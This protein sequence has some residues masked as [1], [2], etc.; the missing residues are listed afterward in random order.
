MFE[1]K[2]PDLG[3]GVA[4]GQ[5]VS[6]L[7]KEGDAVDEFQPMFEVETDKAA[8]E[9][10]A[11]KSGTV[12]EVL[13]EK[14]QTVQVGEVLIKIDDAGDGGDGEDEKKTD[15]E[16]KSEAPPKEEQQ[17]DKQPEQKAGAQKKQPEKEKDAAPQTEA[18]P[19][20]AEQESADGV[21]PAAPAVRKLAREK[22]VD[23]RKV[24]PTGPRGR[25]LRED[26]E[27]AALSSDGGAL[28]SGGGAPMEVRVGELPD[29]TQWGPVRREPAP[30]IRKTIAKQM[31]TSWL[32][33]TRV[34]QT[35]SADITILEEARQQHNKRAGKSGTKMT[36]TVIILKMIAANL[37][38]HPKLNCSYDPSSGEIIWKDYVHIGVAVDTPRGLVVPVIRDVDQKPLATIADELNDIVGRAREAKFDVSELR[39]GTF[40]L[41]N[42]GPLGG[43]FFTPMVN[44]PEVGIL[45]LG[46]A[47]EQAVVRNGEIVPRLILPLSISYDHR[48]IDGA[49]GARF[50]GDLKSALESPLGVVSLL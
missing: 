49:D 50:C 22:G 5:I 12:S 39:G 47:S 38:K 29:F 28:P 41:T 23:L 7:V 33:V 27:R 36:M 2:L 14:G 42:L 18:Q 4:E 44:Y 43:E 11:P 45:G 48:I 16:K 46:R 21:I 30:Q 20:A 17:E 15:K 8:V 10:P 13:V 35:E 26:V 9:I 40:T 1:F 37:K 31:T 32:N 19:S 24:K 25:V 3:E 6:V 34:T